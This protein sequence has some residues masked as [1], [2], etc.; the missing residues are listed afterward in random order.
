ML[1]INLEYANLISEV[2]RSDETDSRNC[3]TFTNTRLPGLVIDKVP[4]VTVRSTAWRKALLEMEWFLSGERRCPD[5]LLDWWEGQLNDKNEYVG[6]YGEQL[7]YSGIDCSF[8]QVLA[9]MNSLKTNPNSRRLVMTTWNPADMFNITDLN[10]N[11]KT[12]TCCHSII[13]QFFVRNGTLHMTSYQ[14]SADML[15]GVPHNWIQS[16]AMLIWF[17]RHTNLKVGTIYWLF[18]DAHVYNEPSHIGAANS[19][20]ANVDSH[21]KHY[22][23]F[24]LIYRPTSSGFLADDFY[25]EGCVPSPSVK[26][27]PRLL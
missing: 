16:W 19:I 25:L 24:E 22:S 1:N 5:E 13:V 2:L 11:S 14:R 15:L 21:V 12:P 4:L 27:R 26:I 20:L 10:N 17:A 7:R 6:G 3:A 9:V 8:D 23:N 18:G